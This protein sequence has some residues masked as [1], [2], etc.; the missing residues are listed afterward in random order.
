MNKCEDTA[1]FAP[2]TVWG[3][4]S[5][6]SGRYVRVKIARIRFHLHPLSSNQNI[7]SD[8]L[9]WY[10]AL[11]SRPNRGRCCQAFGWLARR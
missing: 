8:R 6:S 10:V 5:A 11:P 7:L 4:E 9:E 2:P 1:A 3:V